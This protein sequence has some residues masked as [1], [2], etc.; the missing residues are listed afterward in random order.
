MHPLEDFAE[1]F[2]HFLHITDTLQTAADFRLL[3]QPAQGDVSTLHEIAVARLHAAAQNVQSVVTF[4]QRLA[5]SHGKTSQLGAR[6]SEFTPGPR[7]VDDSKSAG[8]E[9]AVHLSPIT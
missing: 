7:H 6:L 8:G 3:P 2:G 4:L 9:L 5:A 1:V